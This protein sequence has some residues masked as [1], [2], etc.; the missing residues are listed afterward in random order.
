M[1]DAQLAPGLTVNRAQP[2]VVA[3]GTPTA[4]AGGDCLS[5]RVICTLVSHG[6]SHASCIELVRPTDWQ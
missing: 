3:E 2:A 5:R 6:E 1:M 4:R